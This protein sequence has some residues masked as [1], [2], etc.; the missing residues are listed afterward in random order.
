MQI[1]PLINEV[2]SSDFLPTPPELPSDPDTDTDTE[3]LVTASSKYLPPPPVLNETEQQATTLEPDVAIHQFLPHVELTETPELESTEELITTSP[4]YI[5]PPAELP[6]DPITVLPDFFI[7]IALEAVISESEFVTSHVEV[8]SDFNEIQRAELPEDAAENPEE[9]ELAVF[10]VNFELESPV[11]AVT[12]EPELTVSESTQELELESEMV[13]LSTTYL[14]PQIKDF[15]LTT[16]PVVIAPDTES[17]VETEVLEEY[18]PPV[19]I[20]QATT[21]TANE[22]P[23][24]E[25]TIESEVPVNTVAPELESDVH[26]LPLFP[27][28][29]EPELRI[30]L[31]TSELQSTQTEIQVEIAVHPVTQ[32]VQATTEPEAP[33]S[34]YIPPLVEAISDPVNLEPVT[35]EPV[36]SVTQELDFVTLSS[37]YLLPAEQ[38]T[39]EPAE[40]EETIHPD[41]F[42]TELSLEPPTYEHEINPVAS[43]PEILN[44]S[45]LPVEMTTPSSEYIPPHPSDS[46]SELTRPTRGSSWT[47]R[48]KNW[49]YKTF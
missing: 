29:N 3:E 41:S 26:L 19:F 25:L 28:S 44:D 17:S 13:T 9:P 14:V 21:E 45:E 15:E 27:I 22:L 8:S 34:Q 12:F 36:E 32:Q 37:V 49:F 6:L 46:D 16:E 18:V 35:I 4:V 2:E 24:I 30:E 23:V 20:E 11:E 48:F 5:P 39:T 7:I 43:Q 33:S 1:D 31:L 10:Q 47:T 42:T 38:V 40:S